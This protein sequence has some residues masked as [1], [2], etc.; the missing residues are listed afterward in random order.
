MSCAVLLPISGATAPIDLRQSWV[1][2]ANQT[3]VPR[4]LGLVNLGAVPDVLPIM[5]EMERFFSGA[6]GTRVYCSSL[7]MPMR[8]ATL[9]EASDWFDVDFL[10]IWRPGR[11]FHRDALG[12]LSIELH[13]GIASAVCCRSDEDIWA[14]SS[15]AWSL[16]HAKGKRFVD[17]GQALEAARELVLWRRIGEVADYT[18]VTGT[19]W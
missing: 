13:R 12:H 6:K 16:M 17:P 14:A 9:S 11:L 19:G 5:A 18:P 4:V 2:F 15:S 1:A 3:F 8:G 7:V 10:T